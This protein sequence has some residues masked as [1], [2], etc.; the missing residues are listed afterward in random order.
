MTNLSSLL[1]GNATEGQF[2]V[3]NLGLEKHEVGER[4][5]IRCSGHW[6]Q[7]VVA[8]VTHRVILGRFLSQF[9]LL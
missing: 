2:W 5:L 7:I 1:L 3:K 9:L 4:L 6:G 8:F